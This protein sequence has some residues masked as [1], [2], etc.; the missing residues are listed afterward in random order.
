M[1][2]QNSFRTDIKEAA[3]QLNSQFGVK[4]AIAKLEG[5]LAPNEIV[6]SLIVGGL[7]RSLISVLE[8]R[9][10]TDGLLVLTNDRVIFLQERMNASNRI[11]LLLEQ[12]TSIAY[13]KMQFGKGSILLVSPGQN[14][15]FANI[16][17]RRG[18]GFVEAVRTQSGFKKSKTKPVTNDF[19][20]LKGLEKLAELKSIGVLSEEEFAALKAKI[21]G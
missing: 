4:K 1:G 21:I 8:N 15:E 5:Y 13:S 7:K 14:L 16:D 9:I 6:V 17:A 11:D 19:D 3:N 18:S 20:L 10:V 2:N 12:I